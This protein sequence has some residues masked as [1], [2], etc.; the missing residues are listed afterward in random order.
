[1]NAFKSCLVA[2]LVIVLSACG[3]DEPVKPAE[4]DALPEVAPQ[5][6]EATLPDVQVQNPTVEPY[7]VAA[8]L[9]DGGNCFLDVINGAAPQSITVKNGDEISFGGWVS[10]AGNQVPTGAQLLLRGQ[11]ASYTAP[12]VAG[13]DRPDVADI[14]KNEAL[15]KSGYNLT[16]KLADVV[17]GEYELS[18]LTGT[19]PVVRCNLGAKVQVQG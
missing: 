10:D 19:S 4:A 12:L 5:V 1:M 8:D 6:G 13:G 7:Q 11:T 14:L 3:K 15:S 17:A 16:I 9:A 2:A 18:I